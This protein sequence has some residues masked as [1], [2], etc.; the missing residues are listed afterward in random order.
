[1][2]AME[3]AGV[4]VLA[5]VC[6]TLA[7][8][9]SRSVPPRVPLL[10]TPTTRNV[11]LPAAEKCL[12]LLVDGTTFGATYTLRSDGSAASNAS[13]AMWLQARQ[14]GATLAQISIPWASIEPTPRE[15]NYALVAELLSSARSQGNTAILF[16]LAAIDTEHVSVPP[17]LAHPTDPTRLRDGLTWT[18]EELMDRYALAAI[19]IAPLASYYGA[20]AF[21]LG[22]EV[23]VNLGLHPE[24]GAAYGNFVYS[25][26]A[27]LKAQTSADLAVGVTMTV[28]DLATAARASGGPPAWL[29][30]LLDP[31][32]TDVTP[33]TYYALKPDMTVRLNFSDTV[34]DVMA[35]VSLLPASAG[36]TG[37]CVVFQEFGIPAGYGNASSTD[38]SS[39]ALQATFITDFVTLLH[40]MNNTSP[41]RAAA[42][43]SFQVR[44]ECNFVRVSKRNVQLEPLRVVHWY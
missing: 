2:S 1:M 33:L 8:A 18:S 37:G 27:W 44:F 23:T 20:V 4:R 9:A 15:I 13:N 19:V 29:A 17:D 26:R 34:S 6:I 36:S 22:N 43:F 3:R 12:P 24:T 28:S 14:R 21:G 38:G 32:V 30:T 5:S 31:R 16:N 25:F 7:V 39:Q 42:L 10:H 40:E 35:A 11:G 41:V